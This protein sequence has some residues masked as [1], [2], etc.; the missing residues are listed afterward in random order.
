MTILGSEM[1]NLTTWSL[2]TPYSPGFNIGTQPPLFAIISTATIIAFGIL[3]NGVIIKVFLASK[4]L[5][6]PSNLFI[7][8]LAFGD[9]IFLLT[10]ITT[11]NTMVHD[12]VMPYGEVGCGVIAFFMVTSASESLI[13]M[14][15][16][17]VSRYV[18]IVHPQKK[19]LLTWRT[20]SSMCIVTWLYGSLL[21]SPVNSGWGRLGYSKP[22]WGCT[23]DWTYN[24][25]YNIILFLASQ[26]ITSTIM[27][28]CY[29]SIIRVF[30][31]SKKRVAAVD[32][33]NNKE[34]AHK[35]EE[36][37]LVIQLLVVFCIYNVCWAPYFLVVV[38]ID[39]QGQYPPWAYGL[40]LTCVFWNS[41]VNVLVY[42]YY[43]KVFRAQC[44]RSIGLQKDILSNS[45]SLTQH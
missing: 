8:N 31:Q 7:V 13:T 40:I 45:S 10:C 25:T 18:A 29:T 36:V 34:K 39:T 17:A 12:G 16:I 4:Q 26:G 11:V 44:L 32:N 3:S 37:R 28:Y 23:F 27:L 1:T 19:H 42:L 9:L 14:G 24:I 30:R 22:D 5:R 41:A 15:L 38:I 21:M 33:T 20:C 43:N 2:D 6:T 35:K